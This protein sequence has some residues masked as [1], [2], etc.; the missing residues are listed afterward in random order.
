MGVLI[1]TDRDYDGTQSTEVLQLGM[2]NVA[3]LNQRRLNV[4]QVGLATE[5]VYRLELGQVRPFTQ[6]KCESLHSR[7]LA[8]KVDLSGIRIEAEG[9]IV[10]DVLI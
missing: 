7:S 9:S 5:S 3:D 1:D 2:N 6:S 10:V 8:L 4:G